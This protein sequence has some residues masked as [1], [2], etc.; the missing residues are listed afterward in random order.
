[1]KLRKIALA[2]AFCVS[3]VSTAS[4]FVQQAVAKSSKHTAAASKK[5]HSHRQPSIRSNKVSCDASSSLQARLRQR[6]QCVK[7]VAASPQLARADAAQ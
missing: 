4:V 3:L 1:M 7:R 6:A 5:H 2:L